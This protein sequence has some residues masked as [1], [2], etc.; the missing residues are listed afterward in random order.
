MRDLLHALAEATGETLLAVD[1]ERIGALFS[2]EN[3][4]YIERP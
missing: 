4:I 2:A 3:A 1:P